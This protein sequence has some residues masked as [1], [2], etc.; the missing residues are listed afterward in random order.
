M[1]ITNSYL[2]NL[3]LGFHENKSIEMISLSE[4]NLSYLGIEELASNL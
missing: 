2:S 4:N 1:T 3:S